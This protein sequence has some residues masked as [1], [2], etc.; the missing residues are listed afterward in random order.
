MAEPLIRGLAG[1]VPSARFGDAAD[2][3]VTLPKTD[4]EAFGFAPAITRGLVPVLMQDGRYRFPAH[5]ANASL[6]RKDG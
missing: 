2:P 5:V 3:Y 1:C 4:G 6:E